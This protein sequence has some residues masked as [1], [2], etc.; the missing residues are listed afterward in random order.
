MQNRLRMRQLA[1]IVTLNDLRS[2]R[3][4]AELM[5]LSQPAATK[6]L[7]EIEETLGVMLFERL[8]RGVQPTAY[9]ESV[10]R[11]AQ[12][13]LSDLDSLRDDLVAREAGG[14]GEISIGATMASVPG[15]LSRA[16]ID[17]KSRFPRLKIKTHLSTS[18]LLL[19]QL[20]K[21]QL[22]IVLGNISVASDYPN[23]DFEVLEKEAL[24]I[25]GG[26]HHSLSRVRKLTLPE[27]AE[28]A[29]VLQPPASPIRQ[30]M[31]LAF[32]DAGMPTPFNIVETAS[33][34]TTTTL[35]QGT[36][37]IAVVPT[38]IARHYAAAGMLCILPVRFKFELG[39]YGI[40]TRKERFPAPSM[41]LFKESLRRFALPENMNGP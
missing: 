20:E 14:M 22:D 26:K 28:M 39:P 18:D 5:H 13:M 11:Y 41:K 37:M 27:L 16:I 21:G 32:K 10:V 24:S 30:L 36:E 34:L 31:E 19:G 9:G 1:L 38:T 35:L 12:L 3:K 4:A 23:L 29:W 8:P 7:H 33:I 25:V 6:M 15:L 40:I 2:L 17:L